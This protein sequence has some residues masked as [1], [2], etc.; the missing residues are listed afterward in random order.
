MAGFP[1]INSSLWSPLQLCTNSWLT[2]ENAEVM[3]RSMNYN[4]GGMR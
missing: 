1:T 4:G 3:C 2:K